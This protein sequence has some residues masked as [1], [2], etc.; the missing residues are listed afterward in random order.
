LERRKV[1]EAV[2]GSVFPSV[3]AKLLT[4]GD[5]RGQRDWP[6]YLGL[7]LKQG[8]IPDLILMLTDEDLYAAAPD[9]AEV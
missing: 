3:V 2:P 6:D 4:Y 1:V 5:P 8:H 9:S 7:G